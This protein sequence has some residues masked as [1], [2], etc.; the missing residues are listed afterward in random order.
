MTSNKDEN[1]TAEPDSLT[2]FVESSQ[3]LLAVLGVFI[4][5]I[6]V[7]A[8]IESNWANVFRGTFVLLALVVWLELI[9]NYLASG[10]GW[11]MPPHSLHPRDWM[12][13]A[14][15][16]YWFGLLMLVGFILFCA[17]LAVTFPVTAL[18]VVLAVLHAPI[19][20][21]LLRWCMGIGFI[22]NRSERVREPLAS[23]LSGG[24]TLGVIV[25]VALSILTLYRTIS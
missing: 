12:G 8:Q 5:V 9:S 1:R 23:A 2:Q 19:H 17:Y 22:R 11:R 25:V 21:L 7:S 4:A 13:K 14:Q 6:V 3:R 24:L 16:M 18:Y 15:R 10:A 20:M